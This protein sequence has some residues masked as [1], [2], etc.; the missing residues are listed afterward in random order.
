MTTEAGERQKEVRRQ[1]RLNSLLCRELNM[2]PMT[3]PKCLKR[4]SDV[5][6]GESR[7]GRDRDTH[8]SRA[9][10]W[11]EVPALLVKLGKAF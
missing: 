3:S 5:G 8:T 2:S 10:D 6:W 4:W 9:W 7:A 1:L 11:Q